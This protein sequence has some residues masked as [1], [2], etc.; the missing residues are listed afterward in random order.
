MKA[1]VL[2]AGEGRRLRPLTVLRPKPMIPVGNKPVLEHVVEALVDAGV[3]ELVFVVGYRR[4]RIQ[5]HFGDGDD[6]DA[7]IEYV[8]QEK[9]L[10]TGHALLQAEEKTDGEFLVVNGDSFV[11]SG[12]LA[13]LADGK[14]EG[15]AVAVTRSDEPTDYGVVDIEDGKVVG[16]EEKPRVHDAETETINAGAYRFDTRIFDDVRESSGGGEISLTDAVVRRAESDDVHAVYTDGWNDVSHL[17]DVL[18]V[19]AEKVGGKETE[20]G[21]D[22]RGGVHSTAHVAG[23][24][25]VGRN[26]RV[27]PNATVLPGTSLGDNVRVGAGAVVA[28]SVVFA[29]ASVGENAVVRDCVVA[30]NASLGPNATVE[31]GK[32]DVVVEGELY[33]D[34]RLGG[35]VGDNSSVGGGAC[36]KPG[37]VLGNNVRV[38][39]GTTAD[40]RVDSG[41]VVR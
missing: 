40:G 17:W 38:G 22:A 5:T 13:E 36:L 7:E 12:L 1:V 20:A 11:D 4:E 3:T 6:W 2:A 41:T 15:T 31:G 18:R 29:D 9:Q 39:T 35:V 30:G 34:I 27:G 8:V 32:A 14:G 25:A 28:N 26:V 33:G 37:T 24:V 21:A 23:A 16:L 19:N 10:G